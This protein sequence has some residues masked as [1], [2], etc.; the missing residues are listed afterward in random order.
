MWKSWGKCGWIV[1]SISTD[2]S[3][4]VSKV[5]GTPLFEASSSPPP[6]CFILVG[7]GRNLKA[8]SLGSCYWQKLIIDVRFTENCSNSRQNLQGGVISYQ[9]QIQ[10]Y[11]SRLVYDDVCNDYILYISFRLQLLGATMK[12]T[13]ILCSTAFIVSHVHVH[14]RIMM[15]MYFSCYNFVL[16]IF[17]KRTKA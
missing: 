17:M 10:I 15:Y 13:G 1:A 16:C 3:S 6:Y 4:A 7:E 5:L 9:T 12:A 14:G 2:T 8:S 11:R